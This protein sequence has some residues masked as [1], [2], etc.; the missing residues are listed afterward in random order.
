MKLQHLQIVCLP[1]SKLNAHKFCRAKKCIA[2][3]LFQIEE[4]DEL[5]APSPTLSQYHAHGRHCPAP[6]LSSYSSNETNHSYQQ[7][8]PVAHESMNSIPIHL[9]NTTKTQRYGHVFGM[10]CS[11]AEFVFRS[12]CSSY[13]YYKALCFQIN[14]VLINTWC[15]HEKSFKTIIVWFL[16]QCEPVIAL[17]FCHAASLNRHSKIVC[18]KQYLIGAKNLTAPNVEPQLLRIFWESLDVQKED[19]HSK[20]LDLDHK[21]INHWNA[22]GWKHTETFLYPFFSKKK[23]LILFYSI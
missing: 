8:M 18:L 22:S 2:D 7:G 15:K 6:T 3:I 12:L 14:V 1:L 5:E 21:K 10:R 9:C 19:F 23:K 20:E 4:S 13:Y 17:T 11:S 16:C